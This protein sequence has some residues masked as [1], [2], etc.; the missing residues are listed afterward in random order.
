AEIDREVSS[1]IS[2]ANK[3]AERILRQ[4]RAMLAKLA[5]VLIEKETIER[6]EFDKIIGKKRG[7]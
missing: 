1:L 3:T 5:R 2:Q 4:R 7:A 6:E